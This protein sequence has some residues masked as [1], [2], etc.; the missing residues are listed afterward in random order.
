M[1][2]V[3]G[4]EYTKG[5]RSNNN[6]ACV[7]LRLVDDKVQMRDSKNPDGETLLFTRAEYTAFLDSILDGE[8]RL[9]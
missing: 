1:T 4:P 6:G 9:P 8:L 5:S 7:E 2:N 3:L